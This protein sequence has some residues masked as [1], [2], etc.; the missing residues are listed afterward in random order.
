[1]LVQDCH[2][3]GK[4]EAYLQQ[5]VEIN[6]FDGSVEIGILQHAKYHNGYEILTMDGHYL[7]FYKSHV[8]SIKEVDE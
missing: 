1:M 3:S 8:K 7:S 6:F 2:K 4:L 5:M